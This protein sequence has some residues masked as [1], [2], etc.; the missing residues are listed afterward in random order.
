LTYTRWD[1]WVPEGRLLKLNEQGFALRR[2]LLEA[3]TKKSRPSAAAASASGGAGAAGGAGGSS[4]S[5]APGGKGK[6]KGLTKK[7]E[8]STRKR[9]RETG[10]DT[11]SESSDLSP[12]PPEKK[13][14]GLGA[15]GKGRGKGRGKATGK[16]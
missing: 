6:E 10:H 7:G 5:P 13:L 4:A 3:Q 12:P 16:G 8:S 1:E 14:Q 11:V 2:K 9:T 15:A